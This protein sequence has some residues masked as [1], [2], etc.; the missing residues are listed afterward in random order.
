MYQVSLWLYQLMQSIRSQWLIQMTRFHLHT[1]MFLQFFHLQLY[2]MKLKK[3]FISVD[4]SSVDFFVQMFQVKVNMFQGI[5]C[6]NRAT[7]YMQPFTIDRVKWVKIE[8]CNS[9]E[10]YKG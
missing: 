10:W 1:G 8:W 5:I 3:L 6:I 4:C 9:D 7:I 2:Q